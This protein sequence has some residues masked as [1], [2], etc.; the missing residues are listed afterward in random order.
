MGGMTPWIN[1]AWANN[2][3]IGLKISHHFGLKV[4]T[5]ITDHFN[6]EL[7]KENNPHNPCRYF[8]AANNEWNSTIPHGWS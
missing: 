2:Y 1:H 8:N 5:K 3:T 6:L 4:C 7:G